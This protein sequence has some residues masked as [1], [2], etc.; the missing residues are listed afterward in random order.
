MTD[1]QLRC[2]AIRTLR[3]GIINKHPPGEKWDQL[4][5]RLEYN[6]H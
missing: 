5:A 1:N 4:L 6:L 2:A 3:A